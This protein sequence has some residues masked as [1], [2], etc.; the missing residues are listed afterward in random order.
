MKLTDEIVTRRIPCVKCGCT[1]R[2]RKRRKS[3]YSENPYK[4]KDWLIKHYSNSKKSI[5]ALAKDINIP[6]PTLRSWIILFDIPISWDPD[7]QYRTTRSRPRKA[8]YI[9]GGGYKVTK[10]KGKLIYEHRAVMEKYL[11]RT[12]LP[13]E[14]V[15]H[16]NRDKLD[17]RIENLKLCLSVA[18]HAK[19]HSED[20][21]HPKLYLTDKELRDVRKKNNFQYKDFYTS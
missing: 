15:H 2:Y 9:T 10:I 6:Y 1:C 21:R 16:K 8:Y 13:G 11:G 19:E 17:N 7:R 18:E 3:K 14:I 20:H 12:L 5:H 4:N